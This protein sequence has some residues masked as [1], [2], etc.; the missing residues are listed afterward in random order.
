[1]CFCMLCPT[2]SCSW[3]QHQTQ[4]QIVT[5]WKRRG[6]GLQMYRCLLPAG[7]SWEM[8]PLQLV[9]VR[10]LSQ[11]SFELERQLRIQSLVAGGILLGIL[12]SG[13]SVKTCQAGVSVQIILTSLVA[14]S[15]SGQP[16]SERNDGKL[17]M[18]KGWVTGH[19]TGEQLL[20]RVL[21]PLPVDS[22][23]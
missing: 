5:F 12:H 18:S 8:A 21:A 16:N 15:N 2:P 20:C 19:S 17:F 9:V 7:A 23:L 3:F 14:R 13:R 6:L 1:M 22:F 4:I 10:V 11:S